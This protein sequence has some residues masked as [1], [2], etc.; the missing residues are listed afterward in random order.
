MRPE[1][2]EPRTLLATAVPADFDGDGRSDFAVFEADPSRGIGTFTVQQS[3]LGR[4]A[5][6][7]GGAGDRP[8]AGDF[9]GDGRTDV[10]VYGFSPVEGASRFA[11][12]PSGGGPAVVRP[13]GGPDDRPVAGDFDGDGAT[14]LA[15]FGFRKRKGGRRIIEAAPRSPGETRTPAPKAWRAFPRERA[16]PCR[17]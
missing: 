1:P 16:R 12:R 7:F 5:V 9:D 3:R 17:E 2:M 11:V 10:A 8:I 6:D 14:D 4:M 13:F 15:V